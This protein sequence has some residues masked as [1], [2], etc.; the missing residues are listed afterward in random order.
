MIALRKFWPPSPLLTLQ[1]SRSATWVLS[2]ECCPEN[3]GLWKI[4]L[5][6]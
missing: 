1:I 3:E 6:Y 5:N 4:T 2:Y